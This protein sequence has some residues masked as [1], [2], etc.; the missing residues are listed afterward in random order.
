MEMIEFVIL[1]VIT[2]SIGVI[3]H[4]D[5]KKRV[6]KFKSVVDEWNGTIMSF[7]KE[8]N[9]ES[10]DI[11]FATTSDIKK[12]PTA[13]SNIN[14]ISKD[15]L[16]GYDF[17]HSTFESGYYFGPHCHEHSSEFMYIIHGSI[18]VTKC[19]ND[20]ITCEHCFG[21]CSLYKNTPKVEN[22]ETFVL[23]NG[24]SIYI[25]VNRFHSFEALEDS[26]CIVIGYPPISK[27]AKNDKS[28]AHTN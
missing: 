12:K 3:L 5:H 18:K 10:V 19:I 23:T 26:E 20:P 16:E 4:N 21:S 15:K 6:K 17:I 22:V 2:I 24:D 13:K 1:T 9:L 11:K 14:F 27:V 28:K 8:N 25:D 7:A